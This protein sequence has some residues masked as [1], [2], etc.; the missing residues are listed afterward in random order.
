[1]LYSHIFAALG[2]ISAAAATAIRPRDANSTDVNP[3]VGKNYF[4]NSY[5]AGEL[6]ETIAAFAAKGDTLNAARAKTVQGIGSFVWIASVSNLVNIEKTIKEARAEQKR[7]KKEQIVQLI[8]YDLPD[9]DCSGGESGGEFSSAKNGL[10]LYKKNFVDPY[11]AAV[12]AAPD[13][14]FAIILEPDSL[15]NAITNQN[16]PFCA[17]AAPF[18][19]EGIAYAISKLQAKH[20]HLYIDAAHGG[21]LGWADNLPLAA[22]E[23][24]K[25]VALAQNFTAGSTIRGFATDVS[26]FNPYVANPRANYT[27]WSPSFDEKNYAES[28]AP[29]LTNHSLPA[30]FII[31]Q[32]RSGL[33]NT[34]I[35]WGEWCNVKAGYGLRPTT[36]TNS[37]VVDSIVWAK[38]GGES[39]G[40]CGPQI[41]GK[42]APA[43]GR[44][45]N[46]YTMEL[47]KNADPPLE[48]TY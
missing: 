37:T 41:N 36:E 3:F 32:G 6:K 12:K 8:L 26:N 42:T 15:G 18:Y 5:Y 33:Q 28:L 30:H 44:W 11:A 1:M 23:F 43:A 45:W 35:E 27:E 20:I 16:V 24:A 7:T 25:V 21:W 14:T 29:Y 19:E 9:R 13:L 40:V 46:D 4:A 34:R 10:A 47:V 22:A 48:P 39:D 31:D 38:P 17:G 2:G